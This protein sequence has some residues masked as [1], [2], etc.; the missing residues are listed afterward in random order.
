MEK[1]LLINFNNREIEFHLHETDTDKGE[2]LGEI[3]RGITYP[4]LKNIDAKVILDLGANIGASSAFF[5]MNYP[6]SQIYSFEPTS[7]N[8]SLLKRNMNSFDNVKIFKKGA[9]ESD[10]KE[11]IFLDNQIGGRNSI[12]QNWA[13]SQKYEEVEYKRIG[14]KSL[15]ELSQ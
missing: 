11:K 14:V 6:K 7:M 10:R 8:F 3:L 12:H 5:S 1:S 13:K 2:G 4:I 9:H 15:F